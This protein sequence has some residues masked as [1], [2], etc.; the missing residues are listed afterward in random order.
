M[1]QKNNKMFN[2]TL[3]FICY[4]KG[5]HPLKKE[6]YVPLIYKYQSQKSTG[7]ASLV[8]HEVLLEAKI[9]LICRYINFFIITASFFQTTME[10][11]SWIDIILQSIVS[12]FKAGGQV[13]VA[14]S[15]WMYSSAIMLLSNSPVSSLK[16]S[17]K[18]P[19][20]GEELIHHEKEN[21]QDE[22]AIA[23]SWTYV[24]LP[25]ESSMQISH[26][27]KLEAMLQSY[28]EAMVYGLEIYL[29]IFIW[30]DVP[31]LS[32]DCIAS[33]REQFCILPA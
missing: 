6:L 25:V 22:F 31:H 8:L 23:V 26:N 16:R 24:A 5:F 15:K 19:F 4:G 2:Y 11:Q 18:S 33:W 29:F 1:E 21:E 30:L 9:I 28:R 27:S 12:E 3:L 7:L 17:S 10:M 32:Q 14:A 13:F 20:I